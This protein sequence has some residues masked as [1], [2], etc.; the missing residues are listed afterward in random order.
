MGNY[1]GQVKAEDRIGVL[2]GRLNWGMRYHIDKWRDKGEKYTPA[3]IVIGERRSDRAPDRKR[4]K[5]G[6]GDD[7]RRRQVHDEAPQ[8][9]PA[10]HA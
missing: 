5:G 7:R 3:A 9:T 2:L 6:A 10:M 8:E 1:R 4:E